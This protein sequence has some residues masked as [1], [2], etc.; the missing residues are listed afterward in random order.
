MINVFISDS[1]GPLIY[2]SNTGDWIWINVEADTV[3]TLDKDAVYLIGSPGIIIGSH[4]ESGRLY[5]RYGIYADSTITIMGSFI[6]YCGY[7][8]IN[9]YHAHKSK[10]IGNRIV[11]VNTRN[12]TTGAYI[13]LSASDECIVEGN[14]FE[15]S[16]NDYGYPYYNIRVTGN[17]NKIIS[18]RFIPDPITGPVL[19]TGS[20]NKF[21]DNINYKTYNSGVAT[22]SGDGSTTE[23]KIEHGLVSTPSKYSV[24]PL[25]SDAMSYSFTV[26]VNSTHIIITYDTAPP[27][28]TDN[29]KFYWEAEV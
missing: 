23:F 28:G 5:G 27:S 15:R 4:F 14:T 29:L 21:I 11:D 6:G 2:Y 1:G 13:S 9:L 17:N 19:N 20:G 18:N 24:V 10:I 25:S 8:G 26:T 7:Y 12:F 22:F 3:L 16:S